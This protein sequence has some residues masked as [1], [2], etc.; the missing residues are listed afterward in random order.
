MNRGDF[1]KNAAGLAVAPTLLKDLIDVENDKVI[2]KEP[3]RAK[4]AV[5]LDALRGLSNEFGRSMTVKDILQIYL[6]TG[7]LIY[8]KPDYMGPDYQPVQ[9][10]EGK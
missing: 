4:I 5:D 6:E 8:H 2:I 10:I 7:I 3:G 1:F 9:I